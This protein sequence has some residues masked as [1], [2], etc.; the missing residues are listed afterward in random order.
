MTAA[1]CTFRKIPIANRDEIA[2]RAMRAANELGNRTVA[3]FA[4][5]GKLSLHRFEAD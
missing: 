3:V 5:V 2:I 1:N 4:E